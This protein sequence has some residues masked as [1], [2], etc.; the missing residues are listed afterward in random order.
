MIKEAALALAACTLAA[1]AGFQANSFSPSEGRTLKYQIAIPS[2]L[3]PQQKVPLII[4][5]H[6]AGERGDDNQAQLTHGARQL[7]AFSETNKQPSIIVAP[8]C[9]KG[10]QWVDTPWGDLSHTMPESPSESMQLAIELLD[11]LIEQLPVDTSRIYVSGLS[12]GGYASWDIIQRRPHFFAAAFIVC[13]GADTTRAESLKH[14]PLWFFHGS[15][16]T[17]VKT[18]RSRDMHQAL[19]AAGSKAKY[20][21]YPGVNHNSWTPAYNDQTALSWLFKQKK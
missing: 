10:K 2:E 16:D 19:Q 5:F 17:V 13:G 15:E 9:P 11:S 18:S 6:G 8:Q 7:L 4:F 12:M 1:K 21:E 14:L 20:T 3:K